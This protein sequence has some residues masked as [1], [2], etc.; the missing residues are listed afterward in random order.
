M[1]STRLVISSGTRLRRTGLFHVMA[2]CSLGLITPDES[3][4]LPAGFDTAGCVPILSRPT[5]T[6]VT[7]TTV[8][9]GSLQVNVEYGTEPSVY[10][11][12]TDTATSVAGVPLAFVLTG[13]SS[14]GRHHYRMRYRRLTATEFLAGDERTFSTQKLRGGTFRFTIEVDPHP[15]DKKGSHTL[16]PVTLRNQLADRADLLI[17]LGDAFGDDRSP[18]PIT[19]EEIRRLR[20]ARTA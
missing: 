8:P 15:Y 4:A 12:L 3:A 19:N 6:S 13:L 14:N 2:L 18:S 9:F 11:R 5:D 1:A 7:V 17:D 20:L 10:S 16:W